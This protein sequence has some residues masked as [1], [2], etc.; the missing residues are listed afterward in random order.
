[1]VT[2]RD[3]APEVVEACKSVLMELV[4]V[5]GEFRDHVVVAGGWV[6]G[7]LFRRATE[8][9]VGTL[10]I[11][12]AVDFPKVPH[13]SYQ[14]ILRA[15]QA[16]GYRQDARQPFRFFRDV[17]VKDRKPIVVAVDLLAGEYGGTGPGHRTQPAQDVR[18]RKARGCDLV[19]A[20]TVRVTVEGE[21][22]GGGR[23]RID[24]NVA[25]IVPFL[26]MKGMA[27]AGRLKEKDAY[28]IVYCISQYPGGPSALAELFRPHLRHG[29]VREGLGKIRRQ[30]L[31]V[32]HTGPKWVADFQEISDTEERAIV[33]RRA[34]EQVA[35]W[36][37]DLG[38]EP[39]SKE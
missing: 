15:L 39:W 16:L 23:G 38:V 13:E 35:E 8:P 14:T 12:L 36:L 7:L 37:D 33:Q 24:F 10:D 9:H 2:R 3:Y 20:H 32:E 30:F 28:D 11:D 5:M 29:L 6:P 1:M 25:G 27:L 18:A 17:P 31:S 34:F 22:P 4:H 26:V 19:F 21:F